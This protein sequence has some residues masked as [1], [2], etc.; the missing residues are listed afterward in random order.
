MIIKSIFIMI[1]LNSLIYSYENGVDLKVFLCDHYKNAMYFSRDFSQFKVKE[2][3][4]NIKNN[5][6]CEEIEENDEIKI[7][8]RDALEMKEYYFQIEKIFEGNN[9]GNP[10]FA[11]PPMNERYIKI[12]SGKI[13]SNNYDRILFL[14][15]PIFH[16][17]EKQ[18]LDRVELRERG[19]FIFDVEYYIFL[20]K[21]YDFS[22]KKRICFDIFSFY[23]E[24]DRNTLENKKR[25]IKAYGILH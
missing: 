25:N 15:K 8:K 5:T 16:N 1:I 4:K 22:K 13:P 17:C 6:F 20:K 14:K 7:A 3:I 9:S 12:K 21:G 2:L 10:S 23:D 11:Q 24:G 19:C 18:D